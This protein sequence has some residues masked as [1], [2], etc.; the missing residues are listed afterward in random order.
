M[1]ALSAFLNVPAVRK[2]QESLLKGS[3]RKA[4]KA[5]VFQT[6]VCFG[7]WTCGTSGTS[8]PEVHDVIIFKSQSG[9]R[10]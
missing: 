6:L 1:K 10:I 2:I 9:A 7:S 5:T 4:E 8:G 3:F